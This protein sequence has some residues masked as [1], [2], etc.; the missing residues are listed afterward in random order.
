M[1]DIKTP[2]QKPDED[3]QSNEAKLAKSEGLWSGI[4]LGVLLTLMVGGGICW[5]ILSNIGGSQGNAVDIEE[6]PNDD[7]Q[8]LDLLKQIQDKAKND[9]TAG[10]EKWMYS[11]VLQTEWMRNKLALKLTA[12][13]IE[14]QSTEYFEQAVA[15]KQPNAL[16]E[17]A[18]VLVLNSLEPIDQNF[19]SFQESKIRLS[20]QTEQGFDLLAQSYNQQ[21]NFINTENAGWDTWLAFIQDDPSVGYSDLDN[22][23]QEMLSNPNLQSNQAAFF[24]LLAIHAYETA[25]CSSEGDTKKA[26]LERIIHVEN[27]PYLHLVYDYVVAKQLELQDLQY[28]LERKIPENQQQQFEQD[29]KLLEEQYQHYFANASQKSVVHDEAAAAG[30]DPSYL[31]LFK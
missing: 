31:L 1:T 30:P 15:L 29:V 19:V 28:L 21:C 25:H 20:A 12:H 5:G 13:E 17:Q 18:K 24:K 16:H 6:M 9:A 11:H 3:T 4:F 22:G 14:Q 26:I 8:S 7:G 27:Y 2:Q 10:K 23:Y